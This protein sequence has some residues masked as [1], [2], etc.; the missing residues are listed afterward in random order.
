MGIGS[1]P[2]Q[3]KPYNAVRILFPS[4]QMPRVP[5]CFS[6]ISIVV[7]YTLSGKPWN[8]PLSPRVV[9]TVLNLFSLGFTCKQLIS[10]LQGLNGFFQATYTAKSRV[11]PRQRNHIKASTCDY[12]KQKETT[13]TPG[14]NSM[15]AILFGLKF[16]SNF[17]VRMI[18]NLL[19]LYKRPPKKIHQFE[20]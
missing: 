6:S 11:P 20:H 1:S 17:Y 19:Q 18:R 14:K 9:L 12:K 2:F 3:M 8:K 7:D 4:G 13:I 15:L 10:L 5:Y 16:L